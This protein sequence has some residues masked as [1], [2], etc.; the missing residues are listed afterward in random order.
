M[1]FVF[2]SLEADWC[3]WSEMSAWRDGILDVIWYS[4]FMIFVI[5]GSALITESDY[6]AEMM[7][8]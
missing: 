3:A 2:L 4:P 8:L 1:F 6:L 7:H 5:G